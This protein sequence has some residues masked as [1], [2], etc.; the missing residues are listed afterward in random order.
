MS[1][2]L[3]VAQARKLCRNPS[4]PI[5]FLGS[6]LL[7]CGSSARIL[8]IS[9]ESLYSS[10]LGKVGVPTYWDHS[11]SMPRIWVIYPS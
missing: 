2:A 4:G 10:T 7:E 1:E 5:G 9:T 11:T 8:R 6:S 3:L